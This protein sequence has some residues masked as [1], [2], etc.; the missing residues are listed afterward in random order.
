MGLRVEINELQG[1]YKARP[2]RDCVIKEGPREADFRDC[3]G[4][5]EDLG[6][7]GGGFGGKW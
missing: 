5:G 7:E 6:D 3:G 1:G 2:S 4:Q